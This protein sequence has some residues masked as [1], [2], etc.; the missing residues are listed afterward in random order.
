[1]ESVSASNNEL[2]GIVGCMVE[3]IGIQHVLEVQENE[4]R[5]KYLV[6]Q[7]HF[8][9]DLHEPHDDR[10]V[11]NINRKY[12]EFPLIAEINS[13]GG[14]GRLSSVGRI[15][16][17]T[18]VRGKGGSESIRISGQSR[19]EVR[20]SHQSRHLHNLGPHV[21]SLTLGATP[22]P[23]LTNTAT[24]LPKGAEPPLTIDDES[25]V[26][27]RSGYISPQLTYQ[28]TN[29]HHTITYRSNI[30]TY[31]YIDQTYTRHQLIQVR[32]ILH[33]KYLTWLT[34]K[35]LIEH[36]WNPSKFF[37]DAIVQLVNA[38][39]GQVILDNQIPHAATTHSRIHKT[40]LPKQPFKYIY[41]YIYI[42]ML[43]LHSWV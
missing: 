22:H 25:S 17:S 6:E 8:G 28:P 16:G 10:H 36:K 34:A 33:Q 26:D 11:V 12:V 19:E 40:Y 3:D 2:S 37:E 31:I 5:E 41:I 30:Y 32:K 7:E 35:M 20:T 18:Y 4:E 9:P 23:P 15:S 13:G 1:M 24:A 39:G 21:A 38:K 42:D 27:P 43:Y 29:L 14:T